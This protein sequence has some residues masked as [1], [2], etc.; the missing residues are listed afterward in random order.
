M[1]FMVTC[2]VCGCVIWVRGTEEPDTNA[3]ILSDSDSAWDEGC[4]HLNDGACLYELGE[5]E[6]IE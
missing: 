4:E 2:L 1:K 6:V 3:V 5:S